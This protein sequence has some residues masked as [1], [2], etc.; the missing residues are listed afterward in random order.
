M[1]GMGR[2]LKAKKCPNCSGRGICNDGSLCPTC[3]GEGDVPSG[4]DLVLPE[5]PC[6][7]PTA[8]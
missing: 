4:L 7:D 3:K 8:S 2:V 1:E 5:V 6:W